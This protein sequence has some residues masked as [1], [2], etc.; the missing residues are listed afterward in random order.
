MLMGTWSCQTTQAGGLVQAEEDR[1]EQIGDGPW[2]HGTSRAADGGSG[3]PV[4]DFYVGY[5]GSHWVYIQIYPSAQFYFVGV[6]D[7][8]ALTTSSWQIVYPVR[9]GGYGF[10]LTSE[11]FTI[12]YPDLT[13]FCQKEATKP[14]LT[15]AVKSVL[16]C[17]T[18]YWGHADA[19]RAP[20]EL[21]ISKPQDDVPW[22]Q[23]VATVENTNRVVYAY[24]LFDLSTKRMS[25]LVNPTTG[26]YAIAVSSRSKD[27]DDS[28]WM[29][30]YPQIQPGFTFRNVTYSSEENE[31]DLPT[32]L[33]LVFKDGYQQCRQ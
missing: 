7:G 18:W 16:H 27:L 5:E 31:R 30:V 9:Q 25:I 13:Q 23:G 1:I 19:L 12:H 14:P 29:V 32:A 24:N 3:P 15:P 28:V 26:S 6:S 22:W 10:K 17:S 8:S 33:T 11:S 4:Y 20:E 2:L 21:T